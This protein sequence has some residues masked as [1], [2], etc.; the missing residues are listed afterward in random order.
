MLACFDKPPLRRKR[1]VTAG[2]NAETL[3]KS[4]SREFDAALIF[5]VGMPFGY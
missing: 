2:G 3:Q 4:T 1:R 5:T